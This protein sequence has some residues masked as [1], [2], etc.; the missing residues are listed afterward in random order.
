MADERE[1]ETLEGFPGSGPFI[2]VAG[3]RDIFRNRLANDQ[4][5]VGAPAPGRKTRGG[6]GAHP[7]FFP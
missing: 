5:R 1:C 6:R 7:T 2:G 4:G 3:W